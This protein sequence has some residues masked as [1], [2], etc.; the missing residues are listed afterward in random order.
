MRENSSRISLLFD[1]CPFELRRASI[2]KKTRINIY[3]WDLLDM[4]LR[5]KIYTWS[6]KWLGPH[7]IVAKLDRIMLHSS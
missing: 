6:N 1:Q 2:Y 4:K 7:H 5:N 3:E